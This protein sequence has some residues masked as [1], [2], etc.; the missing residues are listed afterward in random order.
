MLTAGFCSHSLTPATL[1]PMAGYDLRPEKAEGSHDTLL[2]RAA[3]LDNGSTVAVFCV[4]DLL[5]IPTDMVKQLYDCVPR[6]IGRADCVMQ[7]GAT[8]THAA[9]EAMMRDADCYDEAYRTFVIDRIV[10]AITDAYDARHAV[11]A[12]YAHGKADGVAS[13]RDRDRA[14]STYAMPCD[15]LWLKAVNPAE[16]DVLLTT[17]ACHPTVLNEANRL[18]SGDLVWGCDDALAQRLSDTDTVFINGACADLSSRYT[19]SAASYDEVMRL[20][21]RWAE[22]VTNSLDDAVPLDDTIRQATRTL[23]IPPAAFFNE[24]ERRNAL[25]HLEQKISSCPDDQQ[26]REYIACRSVLV[27]PEY[28]KECGCSVTLGS[29]AVGNMVFCSLPFEYASVDADALR[30][31]LQENFGC[32]AVFCGYSNGYEGY[33]PSGRPLDY[34]SGYEDI[35]SP[36]RHDAKEL[37]AEAFP[38]LVNDV[39]S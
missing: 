36:F 23:F 21:K 1:Y 14:Q 30:A 32:R 13:L 22:A 20:G 9:P 24:E 6:A 19:R 25:E 26:K 33:L 8:H 7:F 16:R 38:L 29:I 39:L 35:A 10:T 27:R 3:V 31:A 12:Y 37:V 15:T 2:V 18:M 17:F 34:D 11:T 28:G 5:G 4:V